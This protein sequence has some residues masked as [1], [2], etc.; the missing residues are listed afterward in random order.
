MK[1]GTH[2]LVLFAFE[3]QRG[4]KLSISFQSI[5]IC[6]TM[7]VLLARGHYWSPLREKNISLLKND[8]SSVALST[9]LEV[10]RTGL[11]ATNSHLRS[12]YSSLT[13][14]HLFDTRSLLSRHSIFT[15]VH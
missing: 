8:S 4:S 15:C 9:V 10:T 13:F 3:I 2:F 11:M 5:R 1:C 7:L 12:P 6:F 14:V